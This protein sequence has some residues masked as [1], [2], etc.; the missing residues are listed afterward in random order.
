MLDYRY[1]RKL[2]LGSP[3]LVQHPDKPEVCLQLANVNVHTLK[4]WQ[5]LTDC[6]SVLYF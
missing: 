5:V 2:V 6:I 1:I 3:V 4:Q